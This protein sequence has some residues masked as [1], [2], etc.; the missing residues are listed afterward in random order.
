MPY[1]ECLIINIIEVLN[2]LP[3]FIANIP[4]PVNG[5]NINSG[6]KVVIAPK[7]NPEK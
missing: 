5:K 4:C 2:G 3:V 7:I 1:I 6:A